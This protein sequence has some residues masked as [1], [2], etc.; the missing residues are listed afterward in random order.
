M[1]RL[2]ILLNAVDAVVSHG[3]ALVWLDLER[4]VWSSGSRHGIDLPESGTLCSEDRAMLVCGRDGEVPICRLRGLVLD[5]NGWIETPEGSTIWL[6]AD[7]SPGA[8]GRWHVRAVDGKLSG[9]KD[10]PRGGTQR[11]ARRA[12]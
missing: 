8:E 7:N 5:D 11:H 3:Y 10:E 12:R 9:R 2:S 6:C 4:M 1:M